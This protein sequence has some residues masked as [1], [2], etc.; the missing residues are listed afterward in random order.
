MS[1]VPP[2]SDDSREGWTVDADA[3]VQNLVAVPNIGKVPAPV[4]VRAEQLCKVLDAA[5]EARPH[6]QELLAALVATAPTDPGKLAAI[7]KTYR[8]KSVRNV[9]LD[10]IPDGSVDLNAALEEAKKPAEAN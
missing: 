1:T 10:D 6:R 5:S 2:S 7:L 8:G 3:R 4:Y 9:L